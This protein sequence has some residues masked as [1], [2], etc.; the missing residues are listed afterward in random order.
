MDLIKEFEEAVVQSRQLPAQANEILLK[1]YSLY[2][3]ATEG[4]VNTEAPVN[5][6]DIP[7]QAKYKAWNGLKG[8]SQ[9]EA[10]REYIILVKDL[11]VL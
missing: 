10:M 1:L 11:S 3:Q 5:P 8:K 4:D 6:F 2:K 9:N 7:A